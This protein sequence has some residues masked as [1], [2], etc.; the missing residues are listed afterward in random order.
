MF[1]FALLFAALA[2]APSTTLQ[3]K[4]WHPALSPT[5]NPGTTRIHVGGKS[6]WVLLADNDHSLPPLAYA[7]NRQTVELEGRWE[8]GK[9]TQES[10]SDRFIATRITL[11]P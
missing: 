9:P 2:Q 8:S 3:G 11:L 10:P 5:A 7:M 6:V 1:A 4:L